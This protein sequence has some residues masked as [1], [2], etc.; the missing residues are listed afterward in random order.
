MFWNKY[1]FFSFCFFFFV[2]GSTSQIMSNQGNFERCR[3]CWRSW[4]NLPASA[5]MKGP[6]T[7][8]ARA[9]R[10]TKSRPA[11]VRSDWKSGGAVRTTSARRKF[12]RRR[13]PRQRRRPRLVGCTSSW[14][15]SSRQPLG[16]WMQPTSRRG[17]LLPLL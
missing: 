7:V 16:H 6:S 13:L 10:S 9:N 4:R 8:A 14:G 15:V 17:N 12:S 1:E 3:S 2:K 11:N 5:G